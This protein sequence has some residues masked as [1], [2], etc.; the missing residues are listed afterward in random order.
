MTTP[1]ELKS[2][3]AGIHRQAARAEGAG[4]NLVDAAQRR[5]DQVT[6]RLA[7]IQGETASDEKAAEE[8]QALVEERGQLD[9]VIAGG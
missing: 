4:R 9:L 5:R 1:D 3:L 6:E 8:Y 2:A 7:E